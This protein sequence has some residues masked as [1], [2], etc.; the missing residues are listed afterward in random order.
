MFFRQIRP[1]GILFHRG[2][3]KSTHFEFFNTLGHYRTFS[4]TA[5]RGITLGAT[6]QQRF[7]LVQVSGAEAF[8]E[9]AVDKGVAVLANVFTAVGESGGISYGGSGG[10]G[11]SS[12]DS[13]GSSGGS[14]FGFFTGCGGSFGGLGIWA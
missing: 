5:M 14:P 1:Y 11:R 7:R 8:R 13:N 4:V 6:V 10:V 12:G 2:N 9:T 3:P